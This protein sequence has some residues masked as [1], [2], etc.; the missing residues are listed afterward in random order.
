MSALLQEDLD[1]AFVIVFSIEAAMKIT[2]YGL[3]AGETAYLRSL[4]NVLDFVTV[5]IGVAL[6]IIGDSGSSQL[7]SL[8]SLRT[9]RALRPIRVASRAPGMKVCKTYYY[10]AL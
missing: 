1:F 3:I 10:D 7:S 8:R 6:A 9:L 5:V 2:V 4:W